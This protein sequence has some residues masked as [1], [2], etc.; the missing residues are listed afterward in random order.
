MALNG[1]F[2]VGVA[3]HSDWI[4]NKWMPVSVSHYNIVCTWHLEDVFFVKKEFFFDQQAV[5]QAQYCR[6]M[7]VVWHFHTNRH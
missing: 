7:K 3:K 4:L 6:K 1:H 5:I 2:N